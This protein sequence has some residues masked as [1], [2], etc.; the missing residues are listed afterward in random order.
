[1]HKIREKPQRRKASKRALHVH[2]NR[3]APGRLFR[4]YPDAVEYPNAVV[5][6]YLCRDVRRMCDAV[7]Q[8][9]WSDSKAAE[10]ADAAGTV[11]HFFSRV[12]GRYCMLHG[13]VVAQMFLS[14]RDLQNRPGEIVSHECGHAAM[15][16]ARLRRANLKQMPGEEVMCYALGRMVAQLNR[17][18][19]ASGA[20]Q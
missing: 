11:F 6:V 20:F 1:M 12:N 7:R 10:L 19:Y 4:I 17:I 16:W 13:H 8:Q 2:R 18:C 3:V 14:V 9:G 5:H 15:A